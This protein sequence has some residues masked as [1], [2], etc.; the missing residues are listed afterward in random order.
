MRQ[1]VWEES[2][3]ATT[4]RVTFAFESPDTH[5]CTHT[6]THMHPHT[7]INLHILY[8]MRRML[9]VW[10]VISLERHVNLLS[11]ALG[12]VTCALQRNDKR[13]T[14]TFQRSDNRLTCALKRNDNT[15]IEAL[16]AGT[17]TLQRNDKRLTWH[18]RMVCV[19]LPCF[20]ES[21]IRKNRSEFAKCWRLF[22]SIE[23]SSF[24]QSDLKSFQKRKIRNPL[25]WYPPD[26]TLFLWRE[27]FMYPPSPRIRPFGDWDTFSLSVFWKRSLLGALVIE[28]HLRSFS[29]AIEP[30]FDEMTNFFENWRKILRYGH[31]WKLIKETS[32]SMGV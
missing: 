10:F 25:Y 4:Q 23:A 15:M 13:V 22:Q 19:S 26:V 2:G 21:R 28:F 11:F 29:G 9:F 8:W 5:T 3:W 30:I 18:T 32:W 7:I 1:S 6:H 24:C 16:G 31:P 12:G 17:C 20:V 14:C 27:N